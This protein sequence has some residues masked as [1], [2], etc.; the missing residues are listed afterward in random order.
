M[1]DFLLR[2]YAANGIRNTWLLNLFTIVEYTV[3]AFMFCKLLRSSKYIQIIMT[4]L[5]IG[6]VSI[7]SF[8][9][10]QSFNYTLNEAAMAIESIIFICLSAVYFYQMLQQ[11]EYENPF[12]NP[13][14]WFTAAVLI[15]FAGGFFFFIF[16][17]NQSAPIAVWY[18][19][20]S[21]RL[22]YTILILIAFWKTRKAKILF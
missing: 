19:H 12:D 18:I 8:T 10:W 14:F 3:F 21:I 15:Y 1:N 9:C 20:N 17:E 5:A 13:F 11:M 6:L 7:I 4:V 16:S 2:Y 22:I